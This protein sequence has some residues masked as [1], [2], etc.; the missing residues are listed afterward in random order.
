MDEKEKQIK[1]ILDEIKKSQKEYENLEKQY[2]TLPKEIRDE[3]DE[4]QFENFREK[5]RGLI[6]NKIQ[7]FYVVNKLPCKILQFIYDGKKLDDSVSVLE[8]VVKKSKHSCFFDKI[9]DIE[10]DIAGGLKGLRESIKSPSK[11]ISGESKRAFVKIK[12][13]K[14]IPLYGLSKTGQIELYEVNKL[15]FDGNP[16]KGKGILLKKRAYQQHLRRQINNKKKERGDTIQRIEKL[17]H[18]I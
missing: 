6:L 18:Q 8:H 17:T 16:S 14:N 7:D 11:P 3:S 10:G 5:S 1:S 15:N 13:V 2:D 9:K 4:I 12:K